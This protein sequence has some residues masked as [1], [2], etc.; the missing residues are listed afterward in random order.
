M[1]P[2]L[3]HVASQPQPEGSRQ[4]MPTI[5]MNRRS[6]VA[7]AR[8][9]LGGRALSHNKSPEGRVRGSSAIGSGLAGLREVEDDIDDDRYD[10]EQMNMIN[11]M[12]AEQINVKNFDLGVPG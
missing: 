6:T 5:G 1:K 4:T 12:N 10:N 7:G 3:K 9:A 11:E 8:P 2:T